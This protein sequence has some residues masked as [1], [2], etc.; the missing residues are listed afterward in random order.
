MTGNRQT[1]RQTNRQMDGHRDRL[2]PRSHFVRRGSLNVMSRFKAKTGWYSRL[3]T[4]NGEAIITLEHSK[5]KQ[6]Y[7]QHNFVDIVL[8]YSVSVILTK[9]W[10]F[11]AT[12]Y[13]ATDRDNRRRCEGNLRHKRIQTGWT[14]RVFALYRVTVQ[15][16]ELGQIKSTRR[17]KFLPPI[18]A[19]S[20]LQIA[21][22]AF[23]TAALSSLQEYRSTAD[24]KESDG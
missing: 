8:L 1:H 7:L 15:K 18:N 14:R 5:T 3:I 19:F 9:C 22:Y 12:G 2:K 17:G 23:A 13:K 21:K 10:A 24:K 16:G 6:W 4:H 11:L 20:G